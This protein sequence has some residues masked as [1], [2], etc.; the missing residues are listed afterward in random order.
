MRHP[1]HATMRV[2]CTQRIPSGTLEEKHSC[3]LVSMQKLTRFFSLCSIMIVLLGALVMGSM[4]SLFYTPWVDITTLSRIRQRGKP[5]ILL[6]DEGKEWARF[7]S[8]QRELVALKDIPIQVRHAFL[9]TEDRSFYHH[10]GISWYGIIR[11]CVKNIFSG[12][13]AQG[14]STITQQLVRILFFTPHKTLLRKIKEQILAMTVEQHFSKDAIL[15]SYLN[16]IYFGCGIYGVAAAA[17]RFWGKSIQDVTLDEAA[18]LAGI[19]KSPAHYCPLLHP[20]KSVQRRNVVLSCMHDAGYLT[21]ADVKRLAQQPLTLT[22]QEPHVLC[23]P[24]FFDMIRAQLEKQYDRHTLYTQGLVIK[25]TLNQALQAAALSHVHDHLAKLKSSVHAH[26]DG[27]LVTLENNSGAIKALVGGYS[28][29]ESPFNRAL[30]SRQMGSLFKPLVYAVAA[31]AG[32]QLTDICIDEPFTWQEHNRTWQPHNVTNRFEGPMTRARAL[33]HSNNIIAIKT[34]LELSPHAVVRAAHAC[35][36]RNVHQYPSL[37][38]GCIDATPLEV[39]AYFAVFATQGLFR[40]PFCIQWIKDATGKRI[41]SHEERSTTVFSALTSCIIASVLRAAVDRWHRIFP[42]TPPLICEAIGKTGTTNGMRNCWFA[43]A[44]PTYTT[45][46]YLGRDD[47]QPLNNT[48]A[49]RTALPLW[50]AYNNAIPQPR[51]HFTA[52]PQLVEMTINGVTGLPQEP[53]L[54]ES[55]TFLHKLA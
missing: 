35:H 18:L 31:E 40:E 54:A 46:I 43:G 52:H 12:R 20:E 49:T 11:S 41:W 5:S 36:F 8:D 3:W 16:T 4:V 9:A 55:I 26:L 1:I 6:D 44:T 14:A 10:T 32:F 42:E 7:Q 53:G 24:H 39:A 27:A 33:M 23:A 28:Y 17:Q 19:V 38:L 29:H 13:F 50:F 2:R 45:I 48:S 22:P 37:A 34:F 30:C 15:E 25:T 47:H 51:L 21:H